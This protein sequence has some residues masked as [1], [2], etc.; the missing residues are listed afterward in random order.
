MTGHPSCTEAPV[1]HHPRLV[2]SVNRQDR[3]IKAKSRWHLHRPIRVRQISDIRLH[4]IRAPRIRHPGMALTYIVLPLR[5]VAQVA[6]RRP[7]CRAPGP[8]RPILWPVGDPLAAYIARAPPHPSLVECLRTGTDPVPHR[9]TPA[10]ARTTNT[11]NRR[12]LVPRPTPGHLLPFTTGS[13]ASGTLM[14]LSGHRMSAVAC[15]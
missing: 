13:L 4:R 5:T 6:S 8:L 10:V 14:L 1:T 2:L 9:P 3:H 15:P 11:P 12:S 7:Y